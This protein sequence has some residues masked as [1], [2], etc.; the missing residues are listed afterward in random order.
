MFATRGHTYTHTPQHTHIYT[1]YYYVTGLCQGGGL[2]RPRR[3]DRA[4]GQEGD[5]PQDQGLPVRVVLCCVVVLWFHKGGTGVIYIYSH[6]PCYTTHT[7]P[8]H[9]NTKH[10]NTHPTTKHTQRGAG[11]RAGEVPRAGAA[12]AG[13]DRLCQGL[14]YR[15]V[16]MRKKGGFGVWGGWGR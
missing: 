8:K 1:N 6:K 5:G 3:Q 9:K 11:G 16:L 15:R 4:G 10:V 7:H 12:P 2:L 13:R 14:P